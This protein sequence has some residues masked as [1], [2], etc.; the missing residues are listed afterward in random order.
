MADQQGT[1]TKGLTL[2]GAGQPAGQISV[3]LSCSP[4]YLLFPGFDEETFEGKMRSKDHTFLSLFVKGLLLLALFLFLHFEI[5]L[6]RVTP[7]TAEEYTQGWRTCFPNLLSPGKVNEANEVMMF[8]HP[9]P[10]C[11]RGHSQGI[12]LGLLSF[13]KWSCLQSSLGPQCRRRDPKA[14]TLPSKC[15]IFWGCPT[16]TQVRVPKCEGAP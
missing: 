4:V 15:N 13:P 16:S 9:A 10:F 14:R 6:A 2:G 5:F 8:I 12:T 11:P 3:C 7:C 1:F